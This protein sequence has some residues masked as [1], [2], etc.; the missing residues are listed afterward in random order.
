[1]GRTIN[2]L[3]WK[4][5][6]IRFPLVEK[7]K[8]RKETKNAILLLLQN[9]GWKRYGYFKYWE[10]KIKNLLK[11][12]EGEGEAMQCTMPDLFLT[13]F[14]GREA[15]MDAKNSDTFQHEES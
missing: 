6:Q 13:P 3:F 1:M 14:I 10:N 9:V 7:E 2:L 12:R 4:L 8:K 11:K 5:S 15:S